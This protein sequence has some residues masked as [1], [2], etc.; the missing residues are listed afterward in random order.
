MRITVVWTKKGNVY[1]SP[2]S[3]DM[4]YGDYLELEQHI[5]ALVAAE[6]TEIQLTF[7]LPHPS[8]TSPS[9]L[10]PIMNCWYFNYRLAQ[11]QPKN[12]DSSILLWGTTRQNEASEL[13][14][15]KRIKDYLPPDVKRSL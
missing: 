13:Y 6:D 10:R 15:V 2:I 3:D 7:S 12:L 8:C 5:Q 1:Y 14:I 9:L 11:L 4:Y